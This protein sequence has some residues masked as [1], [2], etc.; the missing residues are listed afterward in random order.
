MTDII[1]CLDGIGV[2]GVGGSHFE[3]I[4]GNPGDLRDF[5]AA[6]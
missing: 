3:G 6:P 1:F 5:I 2:K 4:K